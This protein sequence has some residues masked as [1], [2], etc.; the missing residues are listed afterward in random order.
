[1]LEAQEK[2]IYWLRDAKR[3][4]KGFPDEVQSEVGFALY[5]AQVGERHPASKPMKG[6]NAVEIVSDFDGNTFRGVYTTKFKNTIFVL[7][8]F[9]KKAKNGIA[10]PGSELDLIR[11]RL[12]DA[13]KIYKAVN[14]N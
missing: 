7:H 10:T 5:Q 12:R 1:M 6:L 8:C 2:P 4:L 13:E 11:K 14:E 9:Q 3:Q